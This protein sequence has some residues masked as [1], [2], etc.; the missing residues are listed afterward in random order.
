MSSVLKD[1]LIALQVWAS[2][3][4]CGTINIAIVGEKPFRKQ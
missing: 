1:V 2:S 3:S 4:C